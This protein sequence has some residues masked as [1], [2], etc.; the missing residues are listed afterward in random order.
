ATILSEGR[1][2]GIAVVVANQYLTQLD[3]HI[4]EAIFGNVG[5]LVSFR[6]GTQDAATM[7]PEMYPSFSVDDLLNLPKHTACV[8]LLLDG[9][10]GKP[11]TM[12]TLPDLRLPDAA[13]AAAIRAT[14][15]QKYGSD[16]A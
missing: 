13:R 15:R 14:S 5:S 11:F 3:H 16:A 6:L 4:R 12:R 8:K 7:A 10:A 1:K 2:Y 9:V